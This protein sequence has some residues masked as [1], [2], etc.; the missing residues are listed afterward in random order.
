MYKTWIYSSYSDTTG[1]DIQ[2]ELAGDPEMKK[3]EEYI[4][5]LAKFKKGWYNDNI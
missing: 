4:N 3:Q 5:L 2:F 1:N